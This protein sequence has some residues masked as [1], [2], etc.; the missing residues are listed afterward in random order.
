MHSQNCGHTIPLQMALR[1]I[2]VV[3]LTSR[4]GRQRYEDLVN[5]CQISVLRTDDYLATE[6][7]RETGFSAVIHR[8]VEYRDRGVGPASDLCGQSAVYAAPLC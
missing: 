7:D 2:E 5:N 8:V 1:R 6:G 4:P 3:D